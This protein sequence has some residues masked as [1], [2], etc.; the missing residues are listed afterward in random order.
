MKALTQHQKAAVNQ[1]FRQQGIDHQQQH[2]LIQDYC[3]VTG[4]QKPRNFTTS[5]WRPQRQRTWQLQ[6]V[7]A[8]WNLFEAWMQVHQQTV[9]QT[10]LEA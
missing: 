10:E 3:R 2:Q 1:W 9:Q 8:T 6:H 7:V 5:N 4:Y